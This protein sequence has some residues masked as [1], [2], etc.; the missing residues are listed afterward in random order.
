GLGLTLNFGQDLPSKFKIEA[1][2]IPMQIAAVAQ[3]ILGVFCLA[4]PH[5]P[6]SRR[7]SQSVG[8]VIGLDALALMKQWPFFVFV[9]GSFLIC[10][11]LQFYYTF[12]NLFLNE[13]NVANA[14][15]KQSYGQV[16]EIVFMLLMPL[17]FARLGV[18]WMLVIGMA[19]WAIRYVF[20]SF[21]GAP[22]HAEDIVGSIAG[23]WMLYIG[24]ILHGICY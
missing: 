18:K 10:I 12:T 3:C 20:F 15:A 1:T 22:P 5:T 2:S 24:L 13:L 21:G 23:R 8:D 14:A 16:S 17:F 4:L 19:A 7:E 9:V 11:P 6:P